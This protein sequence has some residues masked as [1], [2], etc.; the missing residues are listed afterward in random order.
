MALLSDPPFD[1]RP[2][3]LFEVIAHTLEEEV[4]TL[5]T[6]LHRR[7]GINPPIPPEGGSFDHAVAVLHEDVHVARAQRAAELSK[8]K[9]ES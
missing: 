6:E 8:S 7:L 1:T 2:E 9:G 5:R 3:L 4:R